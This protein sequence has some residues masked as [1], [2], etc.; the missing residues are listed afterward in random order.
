[1]GP[2]QLLAQVGIRLPMGGP[3]HLRAWDKGKGLIALLA[4]GEMVN[5]SAK[6]GVPCKVTGFDKGHW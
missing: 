3:C 1:M 4:Q 6:E 5:P 2:G